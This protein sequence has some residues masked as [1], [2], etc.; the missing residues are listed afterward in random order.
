MH[1][2]HFIIIMVIIRKKQWLPWESMVLVPVGRGASME[3]WVGPTSSSYYSKIKIKFQM[4]GF[5]FSMTTSCNG[6]KEFQVHFVGA[7]CR[8]TYKYQFTHSH[9]GFSLTPES[10]IS[11]KCYFV[12][13]S[14]R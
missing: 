14:N 3:L 8:C 2:A 12:T 11:G 6:K 4:W 10:C 13:Y 1:Y 5:S 7:V 9:V